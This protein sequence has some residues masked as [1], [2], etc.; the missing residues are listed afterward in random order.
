MSAAGRPVLATDRL[1]LEPVAAGDADWLHIHWN[2]PD[3]R[4][5]LWD[6]IDVPMNRVVEEIA[7]S[8]A[9]F[10]ADGFGL[11]LVR[12]AGGFLAELGTA[13]P[14]GTCGLHDDLCDA[15]ALGWPCEMIE[16]VFTVDPSLWGRG[17]AGEAATA[18]LAH[19]HDA[20][21]IEIIGGG[22][23]RGNVASGWV[24]RRIGMVPFGSVPSVLGP[25][26]YLIHGG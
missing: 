10:G 19:G 25:A 14:I 4:R 7:T 5:W 17:V 6:D 8:D 3:V 13:G 23:D 21:G 24:L 20:C 18:V 22:H 9:H 15:E 2:L 26:D 11:W 16:V 12:P 1:R